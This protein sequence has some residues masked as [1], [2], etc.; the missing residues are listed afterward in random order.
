M[1][2]SLRRHFFFGDFNTF[3]DLSSQKCLFLESYEEIDGGLKQ[4]HYE[5]ALCCIVFQNLQKS[6]FALK[7]S[8][9]DPIREFSFP[10]LSVY[11]KNNSR[12]LCKENQVGLF[13]C[14]QQVFFI[15]LRILC[16]STLLYITQVF[17]I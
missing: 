17:C 9:L 5:L 13:T 10:K 16:L 6:M 3:E 11:T 7:Y 14:K 2:F 15:R 12:V 8:L 4:I 1:F